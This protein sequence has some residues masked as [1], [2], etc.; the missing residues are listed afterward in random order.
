M[1]ANHP[2][3]YNLE[4]KGGVLR[5]KIPARRV[6]RLGGTQLRLRDD[7]ESRSTRPRGR[8]GCR[9]SE[10]D[11]NVGG[12]TPSLTYDS[13]DNIFTPTRGTY[14]EATAGLFSQAFGGD[15][16]FQRVQLI[17]MQFIPLHSRLYLGLRGDGAASFG[18][19]PFYLR[20]FIS[21]R[22]APIMRY[23]GEEVGA[24]RGRTALAILEAF[25]PGGLRGRRRG[26]ERF[27]SLRQHAD[28]S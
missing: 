14:V 19:A 13:R 15:D 26:V 7:A 16:E 1:L 21:L 22:G 27:R 6:A 12:M 25:Q 10:R 4:P 24:D 2:L 17:A 20:P 5:G 11:S 23:Q 28:A 3:R 9:T 18:D 8:R